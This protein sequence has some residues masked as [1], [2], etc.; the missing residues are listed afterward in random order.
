MLLFEQESE[1]LD[2]CR[3]V[4]VNEF[5]PRHQFICISRYQHKAGVPILISK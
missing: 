5:I 3:L 2:L 1:L 4:T